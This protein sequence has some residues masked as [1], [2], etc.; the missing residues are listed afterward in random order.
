M[1]TRMATSTRGP[2]M[3]R[4]S[5]P[6]GTCTRGTD[7]A[8]RSSGCRG[9]PCAARYDGEAQQISCVCP[10]RRA[11]SP[12]GPAV[13]MRTARSKPSS[14]RS[15]VR[16]DRS[17]SND[18]CGWRAPNSAIAGA[19][20]RTPNVM[21][22]VSRSR[23]LRHDGRGAHHALRL[24][25]VREQ[26][27]A[28][29]VERLPR[30]GQREPARRAVQQPRVEVRLE[31]R[32]LPRDRG[33]RHRKA[34][35]GAGKAAQLDDLCECADGLEAVHVI[36]I[37]LIAIVFIRLPALCRMSVEATYGPVRS[38]SAQGGQPMKLYYTPGACSQAPHIVL[39]ELDLQVRAGQGRPARAHAC[40]MAPISAPS[41]RRATCRCSSSTTARASPKPTCCCSTSPTASPARSR[42]RSARSSA[43][44]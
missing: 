6:A 40:P 14:T 1:R 38:P 39:Q 13:P 18:S 41:T 25:E 32:N 15:V 37:A 16:S 30:F 43:R 27:H 17:R 8:A 36:I 5:A 34:F 35:G 12:G 23:A 28:A 11:T 31:L 10:R 7:A 4:R 33:G 3:S 2:R 9:S 42:R 19:R 26:L 20:Y 21:P 22:Q 24:V 29:L 44:S